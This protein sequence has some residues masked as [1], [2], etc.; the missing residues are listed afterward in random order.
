MEEV[1][2]KDIY[3]HKRLSW[4]KLLLSSGVGV[5]SSGLDERAVSISLHMLEALLCTGGEGGT[6]CH[7]K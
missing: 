3:L 1:E 5:C 4:R 6:I 2:D 7:G